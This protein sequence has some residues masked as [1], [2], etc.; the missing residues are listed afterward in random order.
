MMEK[1]K[2]IV[3]AELEPQY[4]KQIAE[5]KEEIERKDDQI[6][7]YRRVETR[8][9]KKVEGEESEDRRFGLI[10]NV[11]FQISFLILSIYSS[12]FSKRWFRIGIQ[13]FPASTGINLNT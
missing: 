10:G 1:A 7:D 13:I 9:E 5:L 3:R 6:T 11:E 4:E 2:K 8:L 12:A